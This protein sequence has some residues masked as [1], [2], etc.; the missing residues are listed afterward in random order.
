MDVIATICAASSSDKVLVQF[1]SISLSRDLPTLVFA[2]PSEGSVWSGYL[3][4]HSDS[5]G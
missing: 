4:N 2:A 1:N 5:S 3:S